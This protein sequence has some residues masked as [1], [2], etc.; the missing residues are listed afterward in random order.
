VLNTADGLLRF[1]TTRGQFGPSALIC[2]PVA[3]ERGLGI[4]RVAYDLV[5]DGMRRSELSGPAR[6]PVN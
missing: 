6:S 2:E 1:R 5:R 4:A 3:D